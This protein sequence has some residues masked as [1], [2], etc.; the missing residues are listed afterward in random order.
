MAGRRPA[1]ATGGGVEDDQRPREELL[2]GVT[3]GPLHPRPHLGGAQ[4]L[5][6]GSH[7]QL[8]GA[9][10]VYPGGRSVA[11]DVHQGQGGAPVT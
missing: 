9:Q 8:L 11:G 6:Q 4:P 7:D 3:H 1:A 10:R 2:A 5:A